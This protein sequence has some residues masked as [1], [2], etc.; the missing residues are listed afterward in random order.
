MT[1]ERIMLQYLAKY[2]KSNNKIK[3]FSF[4]I[5]VFF[6]FIIYFYGFLTQHHHIFFVQS[7]YM[8]DREINNSQSKIA[9]GIMTTPNSNRNS[10]QFQVWI[11]SFKQD[12]FFGGIFFIRINQKL[13]P[14]E[15]NLNYSENV[16]KYIDSIPEFK[17]VDEVFENTNLS[18]SID[19]SIKLASLLNYYIYN[20]TACW[21]ARMTDDVY[22]N[23][24][25]IPSLIRK[26]N[27]RYDPLKDFFIGG[28]CLDYAGESILQGGSG[29]IFSRYAAI[30]YYSQILEWI[31]TL[32]FYEDWHFTRHLPKFGFPI[33]N[34]TL[35]EFIG[36][37][38]RKIY[39]F[40]LNNG[41]K[42]L[43]P[44]CPQMPPLPKC[45]RYLSRVNETIFWHD[46]QKYYY[47]KNMFYFVN[48]LPDNTY[49]YQDGEFAKFCFV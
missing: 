9:F 5:H 22:V 11:N 32:S 1:I 12:W 6:L 47:S 36:H 38:P 28:S 23:R 48:K 39:M 25:Q 35:P 31:R 49:W 14:N 33:Y 43:T 34:A 10:E 15:T 24:Y 2:K 44:K 3:I 20:T 41:F 45:K 42:F 37:S 29:F 46:I 7:Y 16:L 26:L 19:L 8:T 30:M 21:F 4:F 13:Y 27:K 18:V 40:L 17:V